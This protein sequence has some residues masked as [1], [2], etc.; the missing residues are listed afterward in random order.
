MEFEVV[1]SL[2]NPGSYACEAIDH[3]NEGVATIVEFLSHDSEH[4]AHE[5]AAWKNSLAQTQPSTSTSM[6]SAGTH[7]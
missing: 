1:Q 5:Y 3:E 7:V 6:R 4:L 2:R